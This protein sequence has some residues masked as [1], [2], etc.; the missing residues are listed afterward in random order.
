MPDGAE[1]YATT[2]AVLDER[3]V[4]LLS[5]DLVHFLP[6]YTLPLPVENGEYPLST[7]NFAKDPWQVEDFPGSDAT[8]ILRVNWDADYYGKGY[9]R[10]YWPK[11]AA[12]IEFLKHRLVS[13]RLWY[14]PDNGAEIVEMTQEAMADL[15]RY[16][17]HNGCR[18]YN[19]R[20][21]HWPKGAMSTCG[22]CQ[23]ATEFLAFGDAGAMVAFCPACGELQVKD[24]GQNTWEKVEPRKFRP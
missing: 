22:Q 19:E 24:K 7:V 9:E 11:I 1:I 16:W 21:P 17:S 2:N 18:R 3:E 12:V 10:G 6:E 20:S 14:G 5:R 23:G 4:R 13:C 15:W 8:T